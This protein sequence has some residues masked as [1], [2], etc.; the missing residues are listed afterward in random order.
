[1]MDWFASHSQIINLAINLAMLVAWV[2]YLQIFVSSYHRQTRP[3]LMIT[4]SGIYSAESRCL[5][6]NMS[7]ETTYLL[8][9][10]IQLETD[11]HC[12]RYP[13]TEIEGFEKSDQPRD[14]Y[15]QS[16]QG[17][18]DSSKVRDMGS[19]KEIIANAIG[20]QKGADEPD[21]NEWPPIKNLKVTVIASY[22]SEDLPVGATRSFEVVRK[23]KSWEVHPYTSEAT[24]IRSRR[25]RRGLKT[26]LEETLS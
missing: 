15:V 26:L 24:Q 10:L 11:G 3:K 1:M 18:L 23:Q 21:A 22:S 25:E 12:K 13:I 19:F 5:V 6:C 16:R 9:L 7:T 8:S 2:G 4:R 17:P 20:E 14:D